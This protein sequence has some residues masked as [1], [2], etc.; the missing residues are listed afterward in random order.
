MGLEG[1][2]WEKVGSAM[3]V[4]VGV[5]WGEAMVALLAGQLGKVVG[6]SKGGGTTEIA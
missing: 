1:L 4:D 5:A 2:L 6:W 3:V